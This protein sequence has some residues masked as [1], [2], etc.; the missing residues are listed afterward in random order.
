M[1]DDL[2]GLGAQKSATYT[3]NRDEGAE[4]DESDGSSS[5]D[6]FAQATSILKPTSKDKGAKMRSRLSVADVEVLTTLWEDKKRRFPTIVDNPKQIEQWVK[7]VVNQD[8][9]SSE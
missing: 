5:E 3:N 6:E 1:E 8:K 2:E 4:C 9:C 7:R